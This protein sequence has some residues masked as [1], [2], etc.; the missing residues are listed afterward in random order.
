MKNIIIIGNSAAGIAAVESIRSKD[1][2]SKVTV[3]SDEDYTAYCRCVLSYYLA[4]E[5]KEERLIYRGKE[6]YQ[7][8]NIDLILGKKVTKVDPKKNQIVLEDKQK[9][10]YDALVIATGASAKFSDIKGTQKRG[11]FGLRTVKDVK[12][13][14]GLLPV[15]KTA[16]VLGGGLIGLKAGHALKK[17]GIDVKVIVKSKQILSQILDKNAADIIQRHLESNGLEI[18][19][20]LDAAEI[21]GNGDLKAVKLDSGKVLACEVVI[22]GKGVSPNLG[23]IK[24]TSIKAG[25]GIIADRFLKTSV[26]NVFAAGDCAETYDFA[27]E[28]YQVNALWPNAVEQGRLA[29]RNLLGENLAYAGSIGM[30]SVEFFD[31]PVISMG[32]TKEEEGMEVI[33]RLDEN[34]NIYKKI[35]LKDNCVKGVILLGR[36]E[37]SG[38]YLELIRKKADVSSLKEDLLN[39]S[40]NYAKIIDLLGT[41]EKIYLMR[42]G[43]GD[44]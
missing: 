3:I 28:R 12:E 41:K 10:D 40:F 18:L 5:V 33:S 22:I 43:G 9:L 23:L 37:N 31:L 35:V 19:T 26:E 2:D 13:I 16:C 4:G 15:A 25:E 39:G 20:G 29:G 1:R 21:L 8:N 32:I 42:S 34:N 44:V 30:N 36:I 14:L 6:F 11:V 24:D 27:L 17:R 38:L 7:N